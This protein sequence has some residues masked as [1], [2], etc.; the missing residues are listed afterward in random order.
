MRRLR[1]DGLVLALVL[2][3]LPP[4]SAH[5][6][7]AYPRTSCPS[8]SEMK[9][10]GTPEHTDAFQRDSAACAVTVP[11]APGVQESTYLRVEGS[12]E[13]NSGTAM[14][15]FAGEWNFDVPGM[16]RGY[17]LN[18]PP[19]LEKCSSLERPAE[20][21]GSRMMP[22]LA[23]RAA[24][25]GLRREVV[26]HQRAIFSM[27]PLIGTQH[28]EAHYE[29]ISFDL[30]DSDGNDAPDRR[31][32]FPRGVRL[33]GVNVGAAW[34]IFGRVAPHRRRSESSE[35]LT[36]GAADFEDYAK[37]EHY[38]WGGL[39]AQSLF[40]NV[41]ENG[42]RAA[43][44]DQ[45]RDL[46]ANKPFWHDYAASIRQFN[47]RRWNDGDDFLV[48]YTGHP[49]Q[50]AVSEFIEIQNDPRGRELEIGA[51][52]EYWDSRFKSFL[53]AVVYSTHSEISPLGEAGIGNEGGWTYPIH[54]KTRCTEPGT[55][56]H[57]T[58]NTGWVDFIVT[59]T[60]GTLWMLAEDTLDRFVSDRIQG[61]N[62][63][64]IMPKIIRGALNPSRTMANAVRFKAPWYRDWQQNAD[65]EQSRG[66]HFLP[67]D[68]EVAAA[69]EFRR[70][71]IAPY[72]RS[73]PFGTASRSCTLCVQNPGVGIALDYGLARWV[74]V[75]IALEN[76]P[77]PVVK[78]STFIGSTISVGFGLRL[79]YETPHNSLSLAVRPGFLITQVA[80]S[81]R[82][83]G[84]SD[85]ESKQPQSIEN[86][87]IT[88][89]LSSDIKL[90]PL[91][92][93]RFSIGDTI[94]RTGTLDGRQVGIGSPPYISW[95]SKQE[96][97]NRSTWSFA[98]GPVL[99][100]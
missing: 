8:P 3:A 96:Y 89:A 68:E 100:F 36:T 83:Q 35:E 40:F 27:Q 78:N 70:V 72:F 19:S 1:P 97:T 22:P 29:A 73:M 9:I 31:Q 71:S 12:G 10:I 5:A 16:H 67:S 51:N 23:D 46:L 85:L 55:Y 57:Y 74:S 49:M 80:P 21:R 50:G 34:A 42:V 64:R 17:R 76:Q 38:H 94:V 6:W 92:S 13:K 33:D 11:S 61:D 39:L 79:T 90:T 52:R 95:L 4:N 24:A 63:A 75:S 69:Q 58:N 43:S 99:R 47:M 26:P 87:A 86:G 62:R 66:V 28:L 65:I 98:V 25:L 84:Q 15:A 91:L 82:F 93:M 32:M 37:S 56:K 60:A 30:L 41:I 53:W 44:D 18:I 54:C 20:Y 81:A 59:P 14:L 7:A 2:T 77:N 88:L 48:N 45:I